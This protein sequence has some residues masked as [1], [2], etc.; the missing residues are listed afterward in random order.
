MFFSILQNYDIWNHIRG[1]SFV[2]YYIFF[3][4]ILQCDFPLG[5]CIVNNLLKASLYIIMSQA[6]VTLKIYGSHSQ[7][8]TNTFARKRYEILDIERNNV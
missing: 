6:S 5:R 4:I 2:N 1:N 8:Q 7:M 3:F